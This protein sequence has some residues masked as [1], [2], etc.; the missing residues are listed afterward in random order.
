MRRQFLTNIFVVT[1]CLGNI[2][3]QAEA[4]ATV[5][6]DYYGSHCDQFAEKVLPEAKEAAGIKAEAN[7]YD[8]LSTDGYKRCEEELAQMGYTFS[9]FPVL[10]IGNNV[11]QGNSAID[12]NLP[13]EL[14]FFAEHLLFWPG[15]STG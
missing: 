2:L 1:L 5:I 14:M 8:I 7:Y 3:L 6:M 12:E 15:L 9:V 11:Y 10:V 13:E 4:P